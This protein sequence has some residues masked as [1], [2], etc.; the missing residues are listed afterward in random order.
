MSAV[1]SR[2]INSQIF[3][4][5]KASIKASGRLASQV[6]VSAVTI[7]MQQRK[8]FKP[9]RTD[10]TAVADDEVRVDEVAA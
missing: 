4:K 3:E 5:T 7:L 6:F 10:E 1:S 8:H 2:L 9:G